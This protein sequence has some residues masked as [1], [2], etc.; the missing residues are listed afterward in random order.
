MVQ[1]RRFRVFAVYGTRTFVNSWTVFTFRRRA[2][3]SRSEGIAAVGVHV[4]L[5]RLKTL[6]VLLVMLAI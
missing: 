1:P 3:L 2:R 4:V 6:H 5:L